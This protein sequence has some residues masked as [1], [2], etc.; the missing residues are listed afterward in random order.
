MA[1]WE[2]LIF[3]KDI[4]KLTE[5]LYSKEKKRKIKNPLMTVCQKVP[6]SKS[7]INA[8]F[9]LKNT[10]LEDHFLLKILYSC[11]NF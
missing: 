11:F 5:P 7:K 8:I 10:N 9:S 1:F 2:K 3:H 6:T 4:I